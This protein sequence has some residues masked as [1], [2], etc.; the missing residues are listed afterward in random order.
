MD[1]I[2]HLNSLSTKAWWGC[3]GNSLS[4]KAWWGCAG[5]TWA[6]TFSSLHGTG[7]KILNSMTHLLQIKTKRN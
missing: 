4:T 7:W 5:K 3:P 6:G 1:E 2:N